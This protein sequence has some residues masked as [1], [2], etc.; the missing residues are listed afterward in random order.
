MN[1]SYWTKQMP[2]SGIIYSYAPSVLT[3]IIIYIPMVAGVL[4]SSVH[5]L[6]FSIYYFYSFLILLMIV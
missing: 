2:L 4:V 5:Q 6:V 1:Y 3:N